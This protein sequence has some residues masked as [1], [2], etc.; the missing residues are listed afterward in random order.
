MR[1]ERGCGRVYMSAFLPFLGDCG[2]LDWASMLATAFF[3]V[4]AWVGF[5]LLE[6]WTIWTMGY[7]EMGNEKSDIWIWSVFV[8][9]TFAALGEENDENVGDMENL[10][11]IVRVYD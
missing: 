9:T 11:L 8:D 7:G 10:N 3:G 5:Q 6:K 1:D 2:F 4:W